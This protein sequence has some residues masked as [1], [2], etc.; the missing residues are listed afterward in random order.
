[1]L[2]LAKIASLWAFAAAVAYTDL[3]YRRVPNRLIAAGLA[4]GLACAACAGLNALIRGLEGMSLGLCLLY[5]AF[6]FHAVGGGDV[7]CLA[8]IGLFAGPHL[9]WVSF[10]RGSLA[11]GAAALALIV[12][13][14]IRSRRGREATGRPEAGHTLPYAA[15]MAVA[16]GLTLTSQCAFL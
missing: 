8:V 3:R 13:R 2:G 11:A 1:M 6:A 5:P 4:C 16:A 10:W 9:L 14:L 12:A 7:K 15:I